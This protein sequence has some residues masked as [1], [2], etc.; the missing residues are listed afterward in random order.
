MDYIPLIN[1]YG[2]SLDEYQRPIARKLFKNLVKNGWTYEQ[3]YWGIRLLKGRPIEQ[4]KGLFYFNDYIEEIQEKVEE[5]HKMINASYEQKLKELDTLV[6]FGMDSVPDEYKDDLW[7]F[8]DKIYNSDIEYTREEIEEELNHLYEKC[9]L[10]PS[11]EFP[12]EELDKDEIYFR[13]YFYSRT[14]NYK[15]GRY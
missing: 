8:D 7:L 15:S 11:F 2:A 13:K 3:I 9:Y 4:Y 12:L 14:G 10:I 1:K 5:A 6:G